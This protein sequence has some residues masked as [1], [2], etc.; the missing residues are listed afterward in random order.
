MSLTKKLV[1]GSAIQLSNL[2]LE[3]I[4]GFLLLPFLIENLTTQTYGLWILVMSIVSFLGLMTLGLSSAVQRYLSIEISAKNYIEYHKTISSSIFVFVFLGLLCVLIS[5]IISIFAANF[6]SQESLV[7]DF[8][9]L[10]ILLGCN[11]AI[12]FF[13]TPFRAALTAE[14][15]FIIV[16]TVDILTL[17]IKTILTVVFIYYEMGVVS[18]GFAMIIGEASGNIMLAII[19]SKKLKSFKFDIKLL[20][21]I[22]VVALF[23][24]SINSFIS[25]LGDMLR[26]P[27]DNI[28]IS[29]FIGLSYVTIYSIPVRLLSYANAFILQSLSVLQPVFSK[30][31]AEEKTEELRNKFTFANHLS[32]CL[33]GLLASGLFIFGGNFI[34]LWIEQYEEISVLIIILPVTLLVGISQQPAIMVLYAINKHKYY[35]Y[36]NIIESVFNIILSLVLLHYWGIYGVAIGTVLPMII[37]RLLFLPKYVCKQINYSLTKYY[38]TYF[39]SLL[40]SILTPVVATLT[41]T[42]NFSWLEMLF[43]ALAY[44][45]IY[46]ICFFYFVT[47]SETK[48]QITNLM[49]KVGLIRRLKKA[50]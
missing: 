6:V 3:I 5:Y 22:K 36:Q 15:K 2:L 39:K 20:N 47:E 42:P 8:Q 26:F 28:I 11:I 40:L 34:D 1:S 50:R 41:F 38:K 27:I 29:S 14:F 33:S 46:V 19:A 44:T 9:T 17:L 24:Y 4:I 25:S 10:I 43:A 23:N 18:L 30:L 45:L 7:N 32:F 37:G 12:K 21:K 31:H 16:S 49:N 35:A 48:I 13:S